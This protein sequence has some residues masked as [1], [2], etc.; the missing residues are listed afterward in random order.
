LP[1][2]PL[3]VVLGVLLWPRMTLPAPVSRPA[4]AATPP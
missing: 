3:L 2:A 4:A 1:L